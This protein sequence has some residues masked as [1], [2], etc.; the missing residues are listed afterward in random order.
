V[1]L[2]PGGTRTNFGVASDYGVTKL[3][4]GEQSPEE[5]VNAA[6]SALDKGGGLVVPG[7]RNKAGIFVQRFV[8]R[9]W[10]V[11]GAARLFKV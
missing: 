11:K 10:V 4:G 5:V 8:P 9:S 2:C 6:L 1:T 7:R 3:P